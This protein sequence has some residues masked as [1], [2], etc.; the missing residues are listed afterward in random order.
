[1]QDGLARRD[2]ALLKSV[3]VEDDMITDIQMWTALRTEH[4]LTLMHESINVLIPL[5]KCCGYTASH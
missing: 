3:G 2:L 1:M 4:L 5:A